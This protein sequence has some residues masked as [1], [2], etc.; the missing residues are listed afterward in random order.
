MFKKNAEKFVC[1]YYYYFVCTPTVA[2]ISNICDCFSTQGVDV[3]VRG[4]DCVA[5]DCH[6]HE[7]GFVY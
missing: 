5:V 2:E 3:L 1:D 6:A 4:G 7:S